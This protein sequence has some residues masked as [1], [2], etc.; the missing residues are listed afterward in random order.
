M[1][2][3]EDQREALVQTKISISGQTQTSWDVLGVLVRV[4]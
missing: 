4:L 1:E 3:Q 2:N